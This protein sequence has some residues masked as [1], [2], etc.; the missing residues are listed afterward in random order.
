MRCQHVS[1]VLKLMLRCCLIL[2]Q[3]TLKYAFDVLTN[4]DARVSEEQFTCSNVT[5]VVPAIIACLPA[6]W[7]FAQCYRR[8]RDTRLV[9]PHIVNAGKY[10]TTFFVVLFSSLYSYYKG[11]QLTLFNLPV[12]FFIVLYART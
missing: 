5:Y 1:V 11:K 6:W 7:R 10:S 12:V 9:F 3:S 4:I 2:I 8:Y